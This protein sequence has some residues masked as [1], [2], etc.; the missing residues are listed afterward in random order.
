MKKEVSSWHIGIAAEAFAAAQFA[1]FGIDVSVQYGANQPE[2]DLIIHKK[3]YAINKMVPVSVKGSQDGGWGLIQKYKTKDNSYHEAINEWIKAHG[4][5][6]IFCLVQFKNV[7]KDELPRMYLATP[8]EI[9]RVLKKSRAGNG[10]TILHEYHK[11][12]SRSVAAGTEERIPEEWAFTEKRANQML[13][14]T[15]TE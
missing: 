1:R 14:E 7:G 11:W 10:D 2:Y 13:E 6:T 5:K 12:T 3:D 9:A 4:D 15:T 8:F